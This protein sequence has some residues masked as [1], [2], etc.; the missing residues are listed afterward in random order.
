MHT[1]KT[2]VGKYRLIGYD[3]YDYNYYFIGEFETIEQTMGLLKEKIAK[4][5]G[6]P[7]SFSDVYYIYNDK[8]KALYKGSFDEG[9]VKLSDPSE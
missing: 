7:T 8:E 3:Q 6:M 5:N 4:A 2:P 1:Q 9:I